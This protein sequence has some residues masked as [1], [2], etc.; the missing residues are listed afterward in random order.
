MKKRTYFSK[1]TMSMMLSIA[2]GL[3]VMPVGTYAE[4]VSDSHTHT[5]GEWMADLENHWQVCT[6]CGEALDTAAHTMDESDI[7]EVCRKSVCDY[8][9]G[10]YGI[11]S[12]DEQ[13][14]LCEDGYY[15]ADGELI[16]RYR[17]VFEYYED[18]NVKSEKDYMYD[19]ALYGEA[20]MLTSEAVYLYCENTEYGEVYQSENTT[21]SEDGSKIYTECAENGDILRTIEYDAQ[22]NEVNVSRYEY[23][24]DEQGER[25]YMAI[26]E[27][28]VLSYEEFC[29]SVPNS[30]SVTTKQVYYNEDGSV[31]NMTEYEYEFDEEGNLL[32]QSAS[33]DGVL[34]W[35]NIYESDDE[36]WN[37]L[38]K[39]ITYDENGELVS[40]ISYDAYG[41]EVE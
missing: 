15:D 33:T 3:F 26:Y 25:S 35:E 39:E 11:F 34:A 17:Y 21:Y 37:Y 16:S 31:W 1:K 30:S 27:N 32:Y 40:E 13:G 6:E 7:C 22:G 29:M 8:G 14:V 5:A 36:G 9:D 12:Y 2:M 19:P 38:A 28:E 18:G 10:T 24:Q 20:E 41:N 4:E 23:E